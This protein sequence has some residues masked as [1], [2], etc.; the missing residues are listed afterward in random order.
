MDI[1]NPL[2][3]RSSSSFAVAH[4]IRFTL[5]P[6]SSTSSSSDSTPEKEVALPAQPHDEEDDEP[7]IEILDEDESD[8]A[9]DEEEER[10]WSSFDGRPPSSSSSS[11]IPPATGT[12]QR[13]LPISRPI[14][15]GPRSNSPLATTSSN[16]ASSPIKPT[17]SNSTLPSSSHR[18][19]SSYPPTSINSSLT[20]TKKSTSRPTGGSLP[21]VTPLPLPAPTTMKRKL[22]VVRSEPLH[23]SLLHSL[24]QPSDHSF[25]PT[26]LISTFIGSF[27]GDRER[28]SARN[29]ASSRR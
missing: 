19:A 23:L 5:L 3:H 16:G 21:H 27:D 18:P 15:R 24:I 22:G 25:I 4:T 8:E 11:S 7:M 28:R 20:T 6:S 12:E 14:H 1:S 9:E 13:F 10:F 17:P 26:Q 2:L 29:E